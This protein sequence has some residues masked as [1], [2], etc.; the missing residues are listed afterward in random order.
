MFMNNT[1]HVFFFFNADELQADATLRMNDMKV[2]ACTISLVLIISTLYPPNY[3]IGSAG[4]FFTFIPGFR[5]NL[6]YRHSRANLTYVPDLIPSLFYK[7]MLSKHHRVAK[8]L[9]K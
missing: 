5:R 9:P 4:S 3:G 7:D 6:D 8:A 1:N 2:R